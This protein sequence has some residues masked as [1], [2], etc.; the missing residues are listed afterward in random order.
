MIKTE[1]KR[2]IFNIAEIWF[3]DCLYDVEGCSH[4]MFR[5][6]RPQ[7]EFS[8]FNCAEEITSVIDLTQDLDAI[9]ENMKKHSC[10]YSIKRAEK[11]GVV[12]KINRNFNEFY[13]MYRIHNKLKKYNIILLDKSYL[14]KAHT[15]FTAELNGEVLC[16]HSYIEDQDHMV[17]RIGASKIIE[18]DKRLNTLKGNA[19]RLIHWEAMKYAKEKGI[20]EFDMGGLYTNSINSFKESFGGKRVSFSKYWKDYSVGYKLV[21]SMA[22]SRIYHYLSG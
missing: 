16:G 10:R 6:C 5:R 21:A 8:G 11:E 22:Q 19:S 17:Y 4:V 13:E 20:K 15:L 12:I 9:W 7:E 3:S 18:N 2:L 14:E 1:F